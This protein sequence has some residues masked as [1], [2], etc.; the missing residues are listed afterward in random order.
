VSLNLSAH[1]RPL[2]RLHYREDQRRDVTPGQNYEAVPRDGRQPQ[3]QSHSV[4]RRSAYESDRGATITVA[5]STRVADDRAA[6]RLASKPIDSAERPQRAPSAPSPQLSPL[7]R[8]FVNIGLG[9][10]LESR[11]FISNNPSILAQNEIDALIAG[12]QTAE[13]AGQS[14]KSQ[15]CVHQALLLRECI[16]VGRGG[17]DLFFRNLTAKDG[18]MKESFVKDVKKVY[19]SIQERAAKALLQNE[20]PTSESHSR[21]LPIISQQT[22]GSVS[23]NPSTYAQEPKEPTQHQKPVVQ[24]PDGRLYYADPDGNRL[25]PA[26]SHHHDRERLRAQSN[27]TELAENMAMLS[28]EERFQRGPNV[29]DRHGGEGRPLDRIATSP[30][31][32]LPTLHEDRMA[33]NRRIVGTSGTEEKLDHRKF[34]AR[35]SCGGLAQTVERIPSTAG[36]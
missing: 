24:G 35:P 22:T 28:V 14:A 26:S 8:D 27:P 32:P 3:D 5:S 18:K 16:K 7:A 6:P 20:E 2:L 23:W 4:R 30:A 1:R 17:I 13:N 25:Y 12:A 10:Y 29:I 31:G 9:K 21:K 34:I 15:T 11:D 36:R 19:L 33:E